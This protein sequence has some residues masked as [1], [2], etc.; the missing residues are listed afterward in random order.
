VKGGNHL[1]ASQLIHQFLEA[2]HVVLTFGDDSVDGVTSVPRDAQGVKTLCRDA[3]VL[4]VRVDGNDLGD[5][6]DLVTLLEEAEIPAVWEINAPANERLAFSWLGGDRH[7]PEKGI[8][9]SIDQA[10]RR[11][12]ALRREPAIRREERLR[13]RLAEKAFGAVCVSEA[14]ARYA[15]EGLGMKVALAVPNG[16]DPVRNR[17]DGP[18]AEMPEEFSEHLRVI[19]AGSPIYPWQGLDTVAEAIRLCRE[20]GDPIAFILLMNQEP[21]PGL[22]GTNSLVVRSVP[23]DRVQEWVR[24]ADIGL[25]IHPEYFWSP[26]GFHGSPMKMFDYM[27][28][29]LPV[30]GTD[31]GQMREVIRPWK[32][33]ILCENSGAALRQVLLDAYGRR[34]ELPEMG[35]VARAE[36]ESTY[37][38]KVVADRTLGLLADACGAHEG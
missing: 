12:H 25:T 13:R 20:A 4:Y 5:D 2:G 31:I 24:A 1:H 34:A 36:V 30:V 10:R 11:L 18:R 7:R 22:E 3:D 37:N 35:R 14:L 8:G 6:P 28:C 38:W 23:H 26:W 29:G 19:Y 21:P 33:G 32:N 27:A 15:R 16:G 9:R 17:E